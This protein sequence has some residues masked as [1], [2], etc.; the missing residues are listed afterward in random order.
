MD[1]KFKRGDTF[2]VS[3]N[4]SLIQAGLAT[5]D[6]TGWTGSAQLRQDNDTL[7]SDLE[8]TWIDASESLCRVRSTTST[9][10]WVIGLALIDIQLVGPSGQIISTDT[11]RIQIV[12]DITHA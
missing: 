8:F 7:I 2:D 5:L 6:L 10:G 1:A 4:L 3:G 9:Q 11:Q 12:K